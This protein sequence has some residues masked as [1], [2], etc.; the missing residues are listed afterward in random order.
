MIFSPNLFN[1][2]DRIPYQQTN[3][4]Q[5]FILDYLSIEASL[6][7]FYHRAP[8]L[9]ENFKRKFGKAESICK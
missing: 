6:D 8:K 2:I 9:S 1:E 5:K 3:F 4:F 7:P